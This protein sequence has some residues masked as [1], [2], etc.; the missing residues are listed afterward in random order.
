MILFLII[1]RPPRSTLTDTLF[2]YTTLFRSQ[3]VIDRGNAAVLTN[4]FV[5]EIGTFWQRIA[6]SHAAMQIG[7][8]VEAAT[9]VAAPQ[10]IVSTLEATASTLEEQ[11]KQHDLDA[12]EFNSAEAIQKKVELEAKHWTSLQSVAIRSDEHKSELQPLMR[13]SYAV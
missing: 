6:T 10:D 7:E 13:I 2:P 5:V 3:L 8:V 9:I 12:N 1:R 11:S 4:V